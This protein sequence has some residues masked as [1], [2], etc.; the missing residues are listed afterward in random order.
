MSG[1]KEGRVSDV[2]V[3]LALTTIPRVPANVRMVLLKQKVVVVISKN[4][5]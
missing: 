5:M 2:K 1:K 3:W 4:K